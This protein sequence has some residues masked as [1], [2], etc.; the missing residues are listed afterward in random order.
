MYVMD[1]SCVHHRIEQKRK[2]RKT[3]AD[4]LKHAS[5]GS[6]KKSKRW[7]SDV[8]DQHVIQVY[9]SHLI[10]DFTVTSFFRVSR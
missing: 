4:E 2:K 8:C 1:D 3:E 9:A 7:V 6:G 5:P 10:V